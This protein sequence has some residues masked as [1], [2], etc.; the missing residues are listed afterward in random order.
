MRFFAFM[1]EPPP[2]LLQSGVMVGFL[3]FLARDNLQ[4]VVLAARRL[5]GVESVSD[6]DDVQQ[7]IMVE[8]SNVSVL[9]SAIFFFF[10][11]VWIVSGA[12]HADLHIVQRSVLKKRIEYSMYVCLY[13]CFFSCLFNCMQFGPQD[14]IVMSHIDARDDVILDV[15]RPIEWILTCPL[16][17]LVLPIIG[18]EKVPDYRR[19]TMPLNAFVVLCF[20]LTASLQTNLE[21]KLAFYFC[22][23]TCFMVMLNQ[24]NRCIYDASGGEENL[25]MGKSVM[26]NLTVIVAVTWIPFPIWYALSPEG[27][28]VIKNAAAMKI[29][30]AFLNVFSK[31]AFI[32]Y[33]NRVRADLEV[34]EQAMAQMKL[35][36]ESNDV[37]EGKT[38]GSVGPGTTL[39]KNTA[40]IIQDVLGSMGRGADFE[41]VKD[42]LEGHMIT[43]SD[44]I[45]VL[46]AP[47]CDSIALPWGFVTA[48]KQKIRSQKAE[49]ADA[50]NINRTI[51]MQSNATSKVAA[52]PYNR[53]PTEGGMSATTEPLSPSPTG[54][55]APL[56]PQIAADPRKLR[57][58]AK[59][60]LSRMGRNPSEFDDLMGNV[61]QGER[62]KQEMQVLL[63][64]SQQVLSKELRELRME[65][66]ER[67]KQR[68]EM[69]Q[70]VEEDLHN[71]H[72]VVGDMMG[73]VMDVLERRLEQ[74]TVRNHQRSSLGLAADE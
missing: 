46:T 66:A 67:A 2:F 47:Y 42:I 57:E 50:W 23:V 48:C 25:C 13:V 10:V 51:S 33:L 14:D 22:G 63:M 8:A 49:M 12:L 74:H 27:F 19:W 41:A 54:R 7:A 55:D 21:F 43:T 68:V 56:P 9:F 5:Q 30:V 64:Q 18:G 24:M 38:D 71:A 61:S 11:G 52:V 6:T 1:R 29:A 37:E 16:M 28:N 34:R 60:E 62:E 72:E 39:H 32:F 59:R 4:T 20:G 69:E 17:Q 15:G 65:S 26:R 44:D 36:H 45:L 31:G 70:K 73:K 35:K 58:H 53:A 3:V 40:A